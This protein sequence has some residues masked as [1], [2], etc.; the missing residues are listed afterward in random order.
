LMKK[1][2]LNILV[3][4]SEAA[5]LAK[6]G[7]LGDVVGSLPLA[8]MDLGCRVTVVL[9]AYRQALEQIGDYR[10]TAKGLPVR[11]GKSGLSA[12]I[13]MGKLAP[14][15][16]LCLVRQDE[17]FD[18]SELYGSIHGEY[19]DNRERFIF[20]SRSIPAL[21]SA[22][23]FEPD[24]ILA[25]DWQTGLVMALLHEG[26]LPRTAG[27]FAIHNMGYQGLV[28]PEKTENIGLP[29]EYYR[30]EGLEFYGQMSL[31]KA[32]IVYSQAVITVSPTYAREIRTPEFGAG[33]DGLMGSIKD[34]LYGIL[35]G[36]DY[37]EWNPA[38]D[39][40][41]AANYS[42]GDLAGK[43]RCKQDLLKTM[44]LRGEL[45]D[46]PVIGM[47]TRL[48]DQKGC[49]L[50]AEAAEELFALNTGLVLLAAG[51][52]N[53]Q[54]LFSEL[55]A[56]YPNRFGLKLGFH[57]ALAHKIVAGCDM[58]LIPSLYEPCGLTQMFSLKYGTIPVVRATGGLKDT[59]TDPDETNGP[60]TGFKF[61]AFESADMLKAI[62]R[63]VEAFHDRDAWQA[64]MREGMAKDFSWKRSAKEYLRVFEHAVAVR[65]G[66]KGA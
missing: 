30:A 37:E 33:L 24:V 38:T 3:A 13:L 56:Q 35:N 66:E 1:K 18:R 22:A 11:L 28:P 12:D 16:P 41:L 32:G 36:V 60:A 23:G 44:G 58:F 61:E 59:V 63:A 55:Q 65:R 31:L 20:F 26:A 57:A 14:G 48:F 7:G 42:P 21:C 49:H 8:L 29:D 62:R 45:L 52:E 43:A 2:P 4:A 39:R 6:A 50:V 17:F 54:K 34:R 25:N 47:V 51:D 15:V 5:P 53:Y 40:H 19:P 27:A 9:P 46:M 64:M 10:I